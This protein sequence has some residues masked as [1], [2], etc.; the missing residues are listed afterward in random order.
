MVSKAIIDMM[1]KKCERKER[2]NR[3]DL[4]TSK[5]HC[6]CVCYC[7]NYL[8]QH[9][10]ACFNKAYQLILKKLQNETVY[11]KETAEC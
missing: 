9:D 4:N 11:Y 1:L 5:P 2:R 7:P 6:R 3:Q 8:G 10:E